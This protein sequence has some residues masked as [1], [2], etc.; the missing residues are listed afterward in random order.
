MKALQESVKTLLNLYLI[1][2]R[3]NVS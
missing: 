3:W 1:W 2:D